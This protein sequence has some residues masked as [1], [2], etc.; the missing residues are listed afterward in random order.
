MRLPSRANSLTILI[1]NSSMSFIACTKASAE[2]PT[3][4]GAKLPFSETGH[5]FERC[6]QLCH[7]VEKGGTRYAYREERQ[8]TTDAEPSLSV[9]SKL[10]SGV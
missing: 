6:Y 3:L 4:L 2:H 1:R 8:S 7:I 9:G 5:I 10:L